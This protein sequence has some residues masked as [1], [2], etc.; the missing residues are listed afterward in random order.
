MQPMPRPIRLSDI[1]L[2]LENPRHEPLP[3]E[4]DAIQHLIANSD[5]RAL[6]KHIAEIGATSPLDLMAVVR[7]SVV[8]NGFT[9]AEGNRRLCALK[10]LADP[11][12]ATKERD[13]EYFRKLQRKMRTPI[14]EIMAVEFSTMEEARPWVELRHDPPPGVGTKQWNAQEKA[15]FNAQG[16]G[17][18]PNALALEI[19]DYARTHRLLSSGELERLVITTL[20]RFLGT[21]DVRAA[22]GIAAARRLEINVPTEEFDRALIKFLRDSIAPSSTVNSRA[23]AAARKSYAE[24][25]RAGGHAPTTRGQPPHVPRSTDNPAPRAPAPSA[26]ADA[27]PAPRRRNR[28]D[29]DDDPRVIPR[30]FAAPVDDRV[31]QRIFRELREIDAEQF[32]FSATYLLRALI[33][34]SAHLFLVKHKITPVQHALHS[35]LDKV[36][37]KL[38][39]QGYKGKGLRHL[40]KMASDADSHY[41]PDTIGNFVHGGAVPTRVYV[42]RAWDSFEPILAEIV[43]QLA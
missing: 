40:K 26:P 1:Y 41:S 24:Q 32:A 10:L 28:R 33:E 21:P 20:T 27:A 38:E 7:H 2:D 15:R 13:R 16:R 22:L 25:L 17:N 14:D 35:N 29:R 19:I 36:A 37:K 39:E 18:N 43:R 3:S 9:T 12:K 31:F 4:S 34:Q 8:R 23:D 5:V 6:A 42:I 11:D 30:G